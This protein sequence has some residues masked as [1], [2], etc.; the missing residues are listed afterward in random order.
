MQEMVRNTGRGNADLSVAQSISTG[1]A[2]GVN[3]SIL[4]FPKGAGLIYHSGMVVR[5]CI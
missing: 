2:V 3:L 1:E 4:F 5:L